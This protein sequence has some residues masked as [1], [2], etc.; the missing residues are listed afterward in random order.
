MYLCVEIDGEQFEGS[1]EQ[2][3]EDAPKQRQYFEEGK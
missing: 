2:G 1:Q 3:F